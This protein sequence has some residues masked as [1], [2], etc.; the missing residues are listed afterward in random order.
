[1][2][3]RARCDTRPH[4]LQMAARNLSSKSKVPLIS[5]RQFRSDAS[6]RAA[7]TDLPMFDDG[8]VP[9]PYI[10]QETAK[11]PGLPVYDSTIS[12]RRPYW[13]KIP[14][15]KDVTEAKFLTYTFHV[16]F[17]VLNHPRVNFTDKSVQSS[18]T[19]NNMMQL[20]TFMMEV[21]PPVLH[22]HPD[23]PGIVTREDFIED[24]KQGIKAAPMSIRLPPHILSI[25]DWN[26]PFDD[27]IRRQF[28]PMKASKLED[29]PKVELD[30]LHE[31][32]D[33]PVE[34]FV[35]RYYDKALFLGRRP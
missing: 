22:K 4:C 31:S 9:E 2:P 25:I 6:G 13:Q 3:P 18:N 35:H 23:F 26:D 20:E 19:V 12:E 5:T 14:R 21:L 29:H 7:V 10:P 17:P 27:P 11:V 28:I 33:S 24:V 32:D 16:S 34:G 8:P 1:M 30:S 15:W